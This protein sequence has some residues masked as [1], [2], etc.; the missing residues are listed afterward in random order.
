MDVSHQDASAFAQTWGL[1]F[2]VVMFVAVL[3]YALWPKNKDKF[4]KASHAPLDEE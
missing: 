2:L 4:N 1:I 3:A